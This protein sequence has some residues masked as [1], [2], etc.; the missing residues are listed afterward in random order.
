MNRI[1]LDK[2]GDDCLETYVNIPGSD[3]GVHPEL[4]RDAMARMRTI[5]DKYYVR[6]SQAVELASPAPK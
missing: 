2:D 6:L 5:L 1:Y 3:V 4:V